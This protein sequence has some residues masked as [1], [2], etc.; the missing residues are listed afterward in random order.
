MIKDTGLIP[1]VTIYDKG[2]NNVGMQKLFGITREHPFITF[3]GKQIYFFY[4]TTFIK[5]CKK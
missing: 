3:Y 5:I 1:K 2:T 4:D